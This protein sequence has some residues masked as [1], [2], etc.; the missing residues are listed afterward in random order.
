MSNKNQTNLEV[1]QVF[2]NYKDICEWLGV[3][4]TKGKGRQYHIK[5]FERYCTYH[6][7]GQKFVIDEVYSECQAK[8]ENRG[9]HIS[10]TIYE[11]LM[12]KL[13]IDMLAKEG[14]IEASFNEIFVDEF[15]QII[16]DEYSVLLKNGYEIYAH[17]NEM[18]KGLVREYTLKLRQ[19]VQ[20]C[21]ETSLNRLQRQNKLSWEKT[22]YK[23]T[24]RG[25]SEMLKDEL[26]LLQEVEKLAYKELKISNQSRIN[27]QINNQF[28]EFVINQ[29][30]EDIPNIKSYWKVYVIAKCDEC[31]R[32]ATDKERKDV[33]QELTNRFIVQIHKAICNRSYDKITKPYKKSY[34]VKNMIKIDKQMF[35]FYDDKF[36][37]DN[38]KTIGLSK[39]QIAQDDV[40][41]ERSE[42]F[43]YTTHMTQHELLEY[44][45][46]QG[47]PF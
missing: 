39:I 38:N 17:T 44:D 45:K 32:F 3:E 18:S 19:I 16:E 5:E 7:E 43:D 31:E 11:D 36:V 15:I 23:S 41:G 47:I 29:L 21:F 14:S 10:H 27:P 28:K 22:V 24:F 4:P 13:V 12:D 35:K 8:V 30:K 9:K 6:K 46:Q 42:M 25:K 37:D 26:K 1:G 20:K 40:W 34:H 33:M 2:K